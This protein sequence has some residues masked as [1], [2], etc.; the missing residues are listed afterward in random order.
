VKDWSKADVKGFFDEYRFLSNFWPCEVDLDGVK[1][2]STEHAYQAA[3]TL[4]PTER[5]AIRVAEKPGKAKRL[6]KAVK[7]RDDWDLVKVR[8]MK[9]LVTQKFQTFPLKE[10][11]LGTGIKVLV[12]ANSWGD[13]FWGATW[14]RDGKVLVGTNALGVIL[15]QVRDDLRR[16]L[17]MPQ[18]WRIRRSQKVVSDESFAAL[19][20]K[21]G[22]ETEEDVRS[23]VT[24]W[25]REDTTWAM[26]GMDATCY[27]TKEEA[28][29]DAFLLATQ[30]PES[31]IDV[32]RW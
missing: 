2:P 21:A 28:E 14:D 24:F 10:Q 9:D 30:H 8:V 1:Y 11:L 16:A 27:E 13:R 7:V 32:V 23:F 25:R 20:A 19:F 22:S 29:K 5:E 26:Q 15:M 6:G 3:K 4:N 31:N 17:P 18:G 12:E